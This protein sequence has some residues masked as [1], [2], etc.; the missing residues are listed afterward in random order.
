VG[1]CW[2][3]D[4][5]QMEEKIFVAKLVHAFDFTTD[6]TQDMDNLCELILR[7]AHGVFMRARPRR[8]LPL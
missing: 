4:G 8:P 7:P 6:H 2:A 1:A 3:W 5:A